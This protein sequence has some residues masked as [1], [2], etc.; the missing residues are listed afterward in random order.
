MV[1]VNAF[2]G[3]NLPGE[4]FHRIDVHTLLRFHGKD[5]DVVEELNLFLVMF[6]TRFDALREEI[7][8][9]L[10]DD[11]LGVGL[12][13]I[14][15]ADELLMVLRTQPVFRGQLTDYFAGLFNRFD[16]LLEF[17]EFQLVTVDATGHLTVRVERNGGDKQ[18]E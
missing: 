11:F 17:S 15:P 2:K 10:V 9:H 14:R 8:G 12:L 18:A 13:I 6:R 4:L 3:G 16:V 1:E 5:D 7:V